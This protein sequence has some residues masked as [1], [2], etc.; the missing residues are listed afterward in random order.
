MARLTL[1]PPRPPGLARATSSVSLEDTIKVAQQKLADVEMSGSDSSLSSEEDGLAAPPGMISMPDQSK[2]KTRGRPISTPPSDGDN[3]MTEAVSSLPRLRVQCDPCSPSQDDM[4]EEYDFRGEA[5]VEDQDHEHDIAHYKNPNGV[6]TIEDSSDTEDVGNDSWAKNY[7]PWLEPGFGEAARKEWEG[8]Y[9]RLVNWAMDRS[10]PS[11]ETTEAYMREKDKEMLRYLEDFPIPHWVIPQ[12][13]AQEAQDRLLERT[14]WRGLGI[15]IYGD[16]RIPELIPGSTQP[17]QRVGSQSMQMQAPPTMDRNMHMGQPTQSMPL[18]MQ[19][20]MPH[21]FSARP[22][23][24]GMPQGPPNQMPYGMPP[25][26]PG[27]V[28]RSQPHAQP[29]PTY[30]NGMP[31]YP[32]MA[33]PGPQGAMPTHYNGMVMHHQ[34]SMYGPQTSQMPPRTTSNKGKGREKKMDLTPLDVTLTAPPPTP[35]Y[36]KRPKPADRAATN[37]GRRNQRRQ[38]EAEEFPWN[39]DLDFRTARTNATWND[40]I[41]DQETLDDMAA[42]RQ[43]NV[44]II[45]RIDRDENFRQ[46]S[47]RNAKKK[48]ED[49][50]DTAVGEKRKRIG[51]AKSGGS[52]KGDSGTGDPYHSGSY[53]FA[54][55]ADEQKGKALGYDNPDE[56]RDAYHDEEVSLQACA[57]IKIIWNPG[58]R[59]ITQDLEQAKFS[60][61]DNLMTEQ[62]LDDTPILVRRAAECI[63]DFCPDLLWREIV[64][65]IVSEAGFGNKHIRDRMCHNGNYCDKATITKRIG[66]A[67]GQ[68]QQQSTAKSKQKKAEGE[69]STSAPVKVKG[70][71]RNDDDYYRTNWD[72]YNTYTDWFGKRATN[73]YMT[74]IVGSKRKTFSSD[75]DGS[76][77]EEAPSIPPKKRKDSENVT[78]PAANLSSEEVTGAEAG[79]GSE[80]E[81]DES[82]ADA[83]SV[84]SDT[85]LDQMDED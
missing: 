63:V 21:Q 48:V 72:D 9:T 60:I 75:A 39:R 5:E 8:M 74:K 52:K 38:A 12:E 25:P 14:R 47:S 55:Q 23:P 26:P 79:S 19:Q 30:P 18:A 44:P 43:K 82:N 64:I 62:Q 45:E 13:L 69:A 27:T 17:F 16:R 4:V 32:Q 84:Q 80:S 7:R 29:V 49:G 68:K 6:I 31:V 53:C 76:G 61:K 78:S 57:Q 15:R 66:A 85:I 36:D 33:Q 81:D 28:L 2:E 22:M 73:R 11:W 59:G 46:R 77:A 40:G 20:N 24:N 54:T 71:G 35:P 56:I 1:K 41:Y 83:V 34:G 70:H 67:L 3:E 51:R 65:R 50:E 42:T 58:K 37:T 10:S